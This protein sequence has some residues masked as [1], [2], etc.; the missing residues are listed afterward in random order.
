[1]KLYSI[2]KDSIQHRVA[3]SSA[4]L[5]HPDPDIPTQFPIPQVH[6]T[7]KALHYLSWCHTG[8]CRGVQHAH[9]LD[10][11]TRCWR[12]ARGLNHW[13]VTAHWRL[14]ARAAVALEVHQV[15]G[16]AV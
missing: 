14:T 15:H 2:E 4:Q 6:T 13:I 3:S 5:A 1:M 9:A 7:L 8:I 16:Q 10:P 11:P 12:R